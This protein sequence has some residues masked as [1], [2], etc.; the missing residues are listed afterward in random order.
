MVLTFGSS[1]V[2]LKNNKNT[3]E[4][5]LLDL[6]N[7]EEA[8]NNIDVDEEVVDWASLLEDATD[9]DANSIDEV[10]NLLDDLQDE[11]CFEEDTWT[12]TI[13]QIPN[14][15]RNSKNIAIPTI[16]IPTIPNAAF[17]TPP[18]AFR[19]PKIPLLANVETRKAEPLF[20]SSLPVFPVTATVPRTASDAVGAI[21]N[22]EPLTRE[23]RVERWK[24]K[25]HLRKWGAKNTKN[26]YYGL[27]KK[28]AAK[29]QRVGGKFSGSQV[30]W[31]PVK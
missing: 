16:Y 12:N 20:S 6:L 5:D 29:R 1:Q 18:L 17:L 14:I 8:G 26:E 3:H 2:G 10:S 13:P 19:M 28:T 23:Q 15:I 4:A 27:R 7:N 11:Q 22:P 24:R 9:D 21:N 31:V 30:T 25:R